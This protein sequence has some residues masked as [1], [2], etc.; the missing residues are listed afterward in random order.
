MSA[1]HFHHPDPTAKEFTVSSRLTSWDRIVRELD[2]CLLLCANCHG[3]VHEGM[4]PSYLDPDGAWANQD[5]YLDEDDDLIAAL[6][7]SSGVAPET[8]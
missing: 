1:M 8:E 3:E 7:Q 5:I 2:K 4:H 6:A